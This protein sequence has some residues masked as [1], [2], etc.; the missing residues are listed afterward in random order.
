MVHVLYIVTKINMRIYIM[1]HNGMTFV[2]VLKLKNNTLLCC[3]SFLA[4]DTHDHL[5][6]QK[7]MCLMTTYILAV[8]WY[9]RILILIYNGITIL[10]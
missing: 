8:Q 1:L 7:L 5:L 10:G 4:T 3:I 9:I 2:I 6:R